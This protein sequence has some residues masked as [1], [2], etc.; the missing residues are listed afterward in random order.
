MK[1]AIIAEYDPRFEPHIQTDAAIAHS[2]KALKL[3]VQSSWL[4]TSSDEIE[5][6]A[7]FDAVWVAPGSPY[8][9]LN[10]TLKAIRHTREGGIP[11][12]GTCGGFQH[13]V[14][15]FARNV[16]D[17]I[18]AQHAE[19]DPYA[20]R[21][22]VSQLSCSLAGRE[23]HVSL[24]PDSKTAAAYGKRETQERYYCNF[25]VNP[26]FESQLDSAGFSVAGRDDD[27]ECRVME[28]ASHP[29]YIGTLY[30]PQ[31]GSTPNDPHPLINAFLLAAVA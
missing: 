26:D 12:L 15:E 29:F 25:G 13:M 1:L 27:G 7:S 9:D 6:I 4:S 10:R 30:V 21:L 5:G 17:I 11:T 16:A 22:I 8:H 31:A 20:S 3:D 24:A 14:I 2:A 28:I 19:Y 18:D 23:M